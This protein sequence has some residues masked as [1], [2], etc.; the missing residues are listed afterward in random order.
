MNGFN[1]VVFGVLVAGG[2]VGAAAI[3]PYAFVLNRKKLAEA[4]LPESTLRIAQFAQATIMTA[5]AAAIG[6]LAGQ[7]IGLGAPWLAALLAGEPVGPMVQALPL[8]I[9]LGVAVGVAIVGLQAALTRWFVPSLKADDLYIPFWKR[10]IAGFY[11]GI[12]EEVMMRLG[13]LTGVAWLLSRVFPGAEGTLVVGVFWAANVVAAL[14]FGAG[15]LG[16]AAGI[17]RLT[18]AV[19]GMILLLNGIGGLVFG[20]LYWQHGLLVAMAAHFTADMVLHVIT[21]LFT[22]AYQKSGDETESLAQTV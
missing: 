12:N 15:H 6:L 20:W 4:P 1:W 8:A 10:L 7:G 16:A 3:I 9:L 5:L 2:A 21:P 14:V 11:G 17:T 19:I 18:P 13:L 22:G